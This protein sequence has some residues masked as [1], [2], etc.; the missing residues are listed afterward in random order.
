MGSS[1]LGRVIW[2]TGILALTMAAAASGSWIREK[3][4]G[5]YGEQ[6]KARVAWGL[7]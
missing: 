4:A 2:T 1:S 3:T 5:K 6:A 7:R